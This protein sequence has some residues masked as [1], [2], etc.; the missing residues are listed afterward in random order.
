MTQSL[1]ITVEKEIKCLIEKSSN[2]R[3]FTGDF[4]LKNH[5]LLSSILDLTIVQNGRFSSRCEKKEI[6]FEQPFIVLF[7]L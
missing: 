2:I 6:S 5:K 3:E 1:I 7:R 4:V